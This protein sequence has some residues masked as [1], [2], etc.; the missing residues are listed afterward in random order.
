VWTDDGWR[1]DVFHGN[2]EFFAD[3]GRYAVEITLPEEYVT[4]AT[5]VRDGEPRPAGEGMRTV[6]YT[7]DGVIDFAWV[8]SP[9][10]RSASRAAASGAAA[11]SAAPSVAVEYLYL[12]EHEWSVEPTFASASMSLEAFSGWF[13]PYPYPRLTIV[14]VPKGGEGAGGMEYPGFVTTGAG[15]EREPGAVENGWQDYLA[16]VT[17]HEIAHQWWQSVVATDE[18]R[19][20]WLDEGFADYSTILLLSDRYGLPFDEPER[21]SFV[22]GFLEGRRRSFLRAPSLPMLNEAWDYRPNQYVIAS[23]AK[24]D[25]ALMTL[26]HQLGKETMLRIFAT[27]YERFRF[28]HPTTADFERVAVEVSGQPLDWFFDGLVRG[29]DTINWS[30]SRVEGAEV[31]VEREGA[32]ALPVDVVVTLESGASAERACSAEK[33]SCTFRFDSPVREA[34]VDPERKILIDLDWIDNLAQAKPLTQ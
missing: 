31:T 13:G 1:A 15:A 21:F 34:E 14:D 22:S 28:A 20:P 24:P 33:T 8:A 16:I 5:G 29:D 7:A 23:Y 9:N 27:Y 2:A 3:F 17:V 12:P 10:L 26:E 19:E 6:R 25:L 4:G 18:G 30:V 11:S 32:L